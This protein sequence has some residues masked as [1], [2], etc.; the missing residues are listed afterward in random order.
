MTEWIKPS[1][2]LCLK[3][4]L[5]TWVTWLAKPLADPSVCLVPLYVQSRFKITKEDVYMGDWAA[6]HA[7][8]MESLKQRILANGRKVELEKEIG[9]KSKTGVTIVGS[10]DVWSP[11]HN[12]S[13]AVAADAK[14]GK[15]KPSD[16]LQ[17]ALYQLMARVHPGYALSATPIGLLK[18]YRGDEV[19]LNAE[20]A[21]PQLACRLSRLM[22]IVAAKDPPITSPSHSNCR[23]CPLKHLCPDA[24][25]QQRSSPI[26]SLF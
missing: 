25:T 7:T 5:T 1:P 22:K 13:A 21:G 8:I 18:Y 16:R 24:L 15:P 3:P 23:F 17:V 6:K 26:T 10:I 19:W 11:E 20:Q 4:E 2:G 12:G 14:T 9:I